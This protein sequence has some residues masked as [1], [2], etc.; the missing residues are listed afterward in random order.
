[1]H[2]SDIQRKF[3]ECLNR[4]AEDL[5][6]IVERTITDEVTR[7]LTES[8]LAL[9]SQRVREFA[10]PKK[11]SPKKASP[12]KAS[13]KKASPKK[14]SPKKASPKKSAASR[15]AASKKTLAK[16]ARSVAASTAQLEQQA[17]EDAD[18]QLSLSLATESVYGFRRP[19]RRKRRKRPSTSLLNAPQAGASSSPQI[20]SAQEAVPAAPSPLFVHRRARDGRIHRLRRGEDEVTVA[21]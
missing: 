4:F 1:M 19:T 17:P 14:A 3:Q 7:A 13:P 11:A 21:P 2:V 9:R 12:K 6:G 16:K 5:K 10:S 15:Q 20:E 18:G 8:S